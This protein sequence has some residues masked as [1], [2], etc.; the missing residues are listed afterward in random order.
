MS[1][2]TIY[3]SKNKNLNQNLSITARLNDFI[4]RLKQFKDDPDCADIIDRI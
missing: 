2:L 4:I 3:A 1:D